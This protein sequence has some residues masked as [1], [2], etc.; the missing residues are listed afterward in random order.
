MFYYSAITIALLK[1]LFL[2]KSNQQVASVK[3]EPSNKIG[4]RN[5]HQVHIKY[6]L[7]RIETFGED[8]YQTSSSIK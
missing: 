8:I 4:P 1:T 6:V 7:Q 5:R 3:S 2:S